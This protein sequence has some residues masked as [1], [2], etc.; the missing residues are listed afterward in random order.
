MP[1]LIIQIP[2]YNEEETL[3]ETLSALPRSV[4]GFETVEWLIIDDGSTDDTLSVAAK[5]GVDHIVTHTHNRGLA[6]AFVSGVEACLKRGAD[7]VVNTDADNQYYAGDIPRLTAPIAEGTAD[8]VVGARPISNIEHF[9]WLKKRL[10][11][12]GSWVVRVTSGTDIA[13]A[14]SGFRAISRHA[15]QRIIVY[16][17]YTYT[18]ET[19]IQAG[20]SNLRIK[21][22]SIRINGETRK[23]RL[24]K[25]IFSYVRRSATT[26]LKVFALYR[27]LRFFGI[28]SAVIIA[29][30][31]AI[32]IRF[33]YFYALGDGDGHVQ[34]LILASI[35]IIVGFQACLMA[36]LAELIASN[37]KLLEDLRYRQITTSLEEEGALSRLP[38]SP[39]KSAV[40]TAHIGQA[41]TTPTGNHPNTIQS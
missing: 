25:S 17:E 40:S 7:V 41:R 3:G 32:G 24:V 9:S 29:A 19:I 39:G 1:K 30:G 2:C 38:Q 36:L 11:H 10:Q 34:S 8:I 27:P 20:Q 31:L 15:A 16:D 14:A 4:P 28:I 37:R 33:L 21:S 26:I 13:D 35:L 23:S 12:L 5:H 18:L 22:I 6:T